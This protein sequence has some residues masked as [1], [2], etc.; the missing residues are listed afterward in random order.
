MIPSHCAGITN[1]LI[2]RG[3]LLAAQTPASRLSGSP[4]LDTAL[5]HLLT[6]AFILPQLANLSASVLFA[7]ALGFSNISVAAPVA[8]GVSLAANAAADH[9]LLGDRLRLR[10]A[11]PGLLLVLAGVTLCTTATAAQGP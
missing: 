8:N 1:P 5:H 6:L 3:A 11:L 10:T 4:A 7:W 9:L 2:R